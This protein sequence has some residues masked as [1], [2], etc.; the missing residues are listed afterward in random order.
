MSVDFNST[1]LNGP[2]NTESDTPMF[3]GV[4]AWERNAKRRGGLFGGSKKR[5]AAT[6]GAAQAPVEFSETHSET[7]ASDISTGVTHEP[8]YVAPV[9]PT[10]TSFATAPVYS[11]R[12]VKKGRTGLPMA[13]AAGVV[14]LGGLAAAGWYASQPHD[15][16][17]AQLTPGTESTAPVAPPAEMAAATAPAATPAPAMAKPIMPARAE[18][19]PARTTTRVAAAR[20]RSATPARSAEAE[21]VNTAATL[22][23]AP[24]AYSGSAATPQAPADVSA[25]IP[26]PATSAPAPVEA[27]PAPATPPAA[28]TPPVETP[29]SN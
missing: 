4:P 2:T 1:P 13:V 20:T 28:A 23:A 7:R 12:T 25:S 6:A 15:T 14:A 24:Q 16:G 27:A 22:P 11:T 21:G 10:D 26:A 18:T 29:P 3:A 19:A 9:E 5:P 17:M 8:A